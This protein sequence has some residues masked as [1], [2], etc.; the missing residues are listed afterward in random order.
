MNIFQLLF[1]QILVAFD[2]RH[3]RHARLETGKPERQL[4]KQ[5]QRDAYDEEWIAVNPRVTEERRFPLGQVFRMHHD[6]VQRYGDDH[7]I[8]QQV[9]RDE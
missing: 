6:G 8:Q 4:W 7:Q 3:H 1:G 5:K 9:Y 2:E